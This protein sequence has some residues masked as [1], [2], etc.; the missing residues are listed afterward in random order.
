[1]PAP[2]IRAGCD[3]YLAHPLMLLSLLLMLPASRLPGLPLAASLVFGLM[4]LAAPLMYLTALAAEEGLRVGLLPAWYDVDTVA[5]LARLQADL[6]EL[7]PA[8][9]R[10][11]RG[12]LG[13]VKE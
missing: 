4:A 13:L 12:L 5:D 3:N 2:G 9:A 10:Y 1:M 11:T 6:T 7:P 8:V